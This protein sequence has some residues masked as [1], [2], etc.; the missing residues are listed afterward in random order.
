MKEKSLTKRSFMKT[1][2]ISALALKYLFGWEIIIEDAHS[3]TAF[4][5]HSPISTWLQRRKPKTA[6]TGRY[7]KCALLSR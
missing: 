1:Q 2:S 5:I 3:D 4:E 7:F 6:S